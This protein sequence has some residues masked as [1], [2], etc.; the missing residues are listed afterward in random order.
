[1]LLPPTADGPR[2]IFTSSPVVCRSP[3]PL[4]HTPLAL[5]VLGQIHLQVVHPGAVAVQH[6]LLLPIGAGGQQVLVQTFLAWVLIGTWSATQP[7]GEATAM[8]CRHLNAD[9]DGLAHC[10]LPH[11]RPRGKLASGSLV[12]FHLGVEGV[13]TQSTHATVH[14]PQ[15]VEAA[16]V[17]VGV[18]VV[19]GGGEAKP[20]HGSSRGGID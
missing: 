14:P 8:V 2:T 10:V 4:E 18:V 17:A 19:V 15:G 16:A 11:D 3:S 13:P 5:V 6:P 1:M 20:P 7:E 12:L 9:V